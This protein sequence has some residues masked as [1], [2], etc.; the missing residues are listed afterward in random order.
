MGEFP[1]MVNGC[2]SVKN[3]SSSAMDKSKLKMNLIYIHTYN[4]VYLDDWQNR[5][6]TAMNGSFAIWSWLSVMSLVKNNPS[7]GPNK[8]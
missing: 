6:S 1:S 7:N 8:T 3:S 2:C 4:Y 5:E